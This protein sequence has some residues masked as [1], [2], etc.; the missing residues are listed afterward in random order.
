MA[1]W[2]T[3]LP[4]LL[5][6]PRPGAVLDALTP[7]VVVVMGARSAQSAFPAGGLEADA[8]EGLLSAARAEQHAIDSALSAV[9]I[10]ELE[11][12]H[13]DDLV[14]AASV[15]LERVRGLKRVYRAALA[16]LGR[17]ASASSTNPT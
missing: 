7:P 17:F 14:D 9:T 11:Q 12:R 5:G 8:V 2:L 10:A 3:P 6:C 1:D 4:R 15:Y 16:A 13:A